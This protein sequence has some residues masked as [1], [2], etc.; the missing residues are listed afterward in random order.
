[1]APATSCC[2]HNLPPKAAAA[3][4]Y[5][6][7]AAARPS[8]SCNGSAKPPSNCFW[9]R[10]PNEAVTTLQQ[11][12]A[13]ATGLPQCPTTARALL[14][15]C[16]SPCW[17]RQQGNCD[18]ASCSCSY[19]QLTNN[20]KCCR[21]A[22]LLLHIDPAARQQPAPCCMASGNHERRSCSCCIMLVSSL[23]QQ[24]APPRTTAACVIITVAAIL[25][26]T[27]SKEARIAQQDIRWRQRNKALAIVLVATGTL[28]V[29][30]S[31]QQGLH[32]F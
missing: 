9:P 2:W 21:T 4:S 15:Y 7:P 1:M 32:F 29:V 10:L 20:A 11:W 3:W 8:R 13:A 31:L 6:S 23:Q 14:P 5:R 24:S 28:A 19:R 26:T 27:C 12:P 17:L 22:W 18:P 30:Q 25:C 16:C